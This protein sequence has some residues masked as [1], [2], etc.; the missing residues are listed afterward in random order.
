MQRLSIFHRTILLFSLCGCF[1]EATHLY[2]QEDANN[3]GEYE[4]LM[5]TEFGQFVLDLDSSSDHKSILP[6]HIKKLPEFFAKTDHFPG[7]VLIPGGRSL[8]RTNANRVDPRVLFTPFPKTGRTEE[9]KTPHGFSNWLKRQGVPK[10][11]LVGKVFVG[12]STAKDEAEVIAWS[13]K[14][15]RFEFFI[16]KHLREDP[17]VD[18]LPTQNFCTRCHQNSAPIFPR[19][20]WTEIKMDINQ[21]GHKDNLKEL[22]KDFDVD[23]YFGIPTSGRKKIDKA[24]PSALTFDFA[25]HIAN[26]FA[27]MGDV[28]RSV[29]TT[30]ENRELILRAGLTNPIPSRY[31]REMVGSDEAF[32]AKSQRYLFGIDV[33]VEMRANLQKLSPKSTGPTVFAYPRHMLA[34]PSE[35]KRRTFDPEKKRKN[36]DGIPKGSFAAY[37]FDVSS[38]FFA[39]SDDNAEILSALSSEGVEKIIQQDELKDILSTRFPTPNE[40]NLAIKESLLSSVSKSELLKPR[41]M[42]KLHCQ[43]CHGGDDESN[44]SQGP[45]IQFNSSKDQDRF[46]T[47]ILQRLKSESMPLQGE[48]LDI[49]DRQRSILINFITNLDR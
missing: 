34:D 24:D 26:R 11:D 44:L 8:Q 36:H 39:F 31:I 30:E 6:F 16:L 2:G 40:V 4:R 47:R 23:S 19:A 7:G 48:G 9:A 43:P 21:V 18:P 5:K 35:N 28:I 29:G 10:N 20:P 25:V 41:A 12:Y 37:L 17:K 42:M 22:D 32:A 45:I 33:P 27:Q 49:T 13:P 1:I 14:K 3:M 15:R 38:E 46:A